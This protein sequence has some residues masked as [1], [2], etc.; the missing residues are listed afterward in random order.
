METGNN[1]NIFY[2]SEQDFDGEGIGEEGRVSR[3]V[4]EPPLEDETGGGRCAVVGDV[5]SVGEFVGLD[6][7]F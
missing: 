3:R 5:E 4:K 7:A 2:L 1:K 6:F